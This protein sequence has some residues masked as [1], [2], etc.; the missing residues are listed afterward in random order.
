MGAIIAAIVYVTRR[1]ERAK[2]ERAKA[3]AARHGL[4]IDTETKGPPAFIDVDL[5]DRGR[6]KKV[7]Y[8]M[9]REGEQDSVFEYE[10]TIGSGDNSRTYHV[11]V[12]MIAVPFS[13]PHLSI[14]TENWWTKMKQFAGMRDIEIESPAFNDRYHVRSD[15][16]RFAITL[17]DQSMIAFL[18]SPSSGQ[19][20]I[21]FEFHGP[22]MLLYRDRLELDELP[23]L[24]DWGRSVR[25]VLPA[26]LSEWYPIAR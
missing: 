13:A 4:R 23:A 5:F 25:T 22:W 18:L 6:A 17:L 1:I 26:V 9:W 2:L 10:Y 16:E 21:T 24:L 8:Q 19:G 7:K 3:L 14:T 11:S 15:D 20:D 12:A